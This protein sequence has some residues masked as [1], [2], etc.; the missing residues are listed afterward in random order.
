[1]TSQLWEPE[2]PLPCK[3]CQSTTLTS[4]HSVLEVFHLCHFCSC[5]S[6]VKSAPVV[7]TASHTALKED[8][9]PSLLTTPVAYV[10]T[11]AFS[12]QPKK[13][14]HE[15]DFPALV[16]KVRPP[17]PA[18]GTTSAWSNHTSA[19]KPVTHP[20]PSS[21]PPPPL[22]S[23]SSGPQLLSSSSSSSSRRKKKVG[24]NGK[25]SSNYSPLHSDDESGGMTQQEFR[26]VP[27]ML[28]IS[29]LLTV[30][31]DGSKSS[32]PAGSSSTSNP[33]PNTDLPT[34]KANKKKKQKNT[35]APS[36]SASTTSDLAT[37]A[38]PIAVET[39]AQKENVPQNKPLSNT[40]K[41]VLTSGLAN[42]YT[43][44]SPPTSKDIAVVTP[45]P[46]TQPADDQEEEFPALMTKKP[47]PGTAQQS[48]G[49]IYDHF[50]SSITSF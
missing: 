33:T 32:N 7:T 36:T 9:F 46:N 24:E 22:S 42:G 29:S 25:P 48:A 28:D 43:E 10:M 14:F 35:A 12:A 26:S 39:T 1:M 49:F 16:S 47:P 38:N 17:K 8:D 31:A 13:A 3:I 20:P 41:A 19:A 50:T 18:A 27:T 44:Q 37:P 45:R 21:R 11:P 6:S 5:D 15:E 34:P 2:L 23:A 40:V 30:K 4:H